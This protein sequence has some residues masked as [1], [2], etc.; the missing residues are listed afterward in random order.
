MNTSSPKKYKNKKRSPS[1]EPKWNIERLNDQG[2][3]RITMDIKFKHVPVLLMSEL[4]KY[5]TGKNFIS[6]KRPLFN[7]L[8]L[9]EKE[10][11]LHI[12]MSQT[13]K[14]IAASLSIAEDTV[15]THRKNIMRKLQCTSAK[16]LEK[17]KALY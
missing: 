16:E 9:R 1:M 2:I 5:I 17:Y 4:N 15:K 6:T 3:L 11:L 12:I 14:Q 8:S 13:S 7:T 10:I